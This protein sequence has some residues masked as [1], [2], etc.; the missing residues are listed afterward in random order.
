MIKFY[1]DKCN[2]N[3]FI[4][5]DD[6][7]DYK[8][9]YNCYKHLSKYEFKNILS[10][11]DVLLH[12]AKKFHKYNTLSFNNSLDYENGIRYNDVVN[13]YNYYFYGRS[14]LY[15]ECLKII[16]SSYKKQTR[17]TNKILSML[18]HGKCYFLTMTFDDYILNNSTKIQRKEYVK[19]WLKNNY[20]SGVANIDFGNE[21]VYYDRRNNKRIST[22]R[23][24]YHA[25]VLSKKDYVVDYNSWCK[26][27]IVNSSGE[28]TSKNCY[29]NAEYIP[30][31]TG[32]ITE[33]SAIAPYLN[34]L[35]LHALKKSTK[36]ENLIYFG[37]R[38]KK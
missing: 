7:I 26:Y 35:S 31:V 24:H 36:R 11:F 1:P 9:L 6:T 16:N 14:W 15:K 28:I 19:K 3:Y 18:A 2:K 4:E 17:V 10:N 34:K 23:E 27:D 5:I 37:F 38:K 30:C 13:L 20:D 8:Y 29:F 25:V 21:K 12:V 22:K 33:I 32:E